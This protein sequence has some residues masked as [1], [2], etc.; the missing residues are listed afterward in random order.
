MPEACQLPRDRK[1]SLRLNKQHAFIQEL[2]IG[3][4]IHSRIPVGE[5]ADVAGGACGTDA[6]LMDYACP[7]TARQ[8]VRLVRSD[9]SS[10]Q[11]PRVQSLPVKLVAQ[12][13][14]KPFP[15][16]Y[17]NSFDPVKIRL[18]IAAV[19][20]ADLKTDD[21]RRLGNPESACPMILCCFMKPANASQN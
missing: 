21:S 13:M 19:P 15:K 5:C 9:I 16:E 6:W 11:F 2:N 4:L 20:V 12:T 10:S 7:I 3:Q 1:E 18:V 14:T 8:E 17:H